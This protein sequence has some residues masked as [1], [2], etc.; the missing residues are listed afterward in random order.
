VTNATDTS[1]TTAAQDVTRS[2]REILRATAMT[3]GAFL[4]VLCLSMVRMK[5][6]ALA[7]GPDGIGFVGLLT[8]VLDMAIAVAGLGIQAS[9]VRQI[10]ESAGRNDERSIASVVRAVRWASWVSGLAGA[11]IVALLALPLSSLTFGTPAHGPD[12]LV[13]AAAVLLR[14]LAAGQASVL[15][16]TRRIGDLALI[17]I[18]GALAATIAMVPAAYFWGQTG[19][20]GALLAA[21]A[22]H[23]A[24]SGWFARKVRFAE[25]P[26]W[27]ETRRELPALLQMGVAFMVSGLVTFGVAYLMRI[28]VLRHGG[29]AEA[30]L[31]QAAW[32]IASLYASFVL[33]AMSTDFY[34]RLTGL[35]DQTEAN[36]LVNEQ[37]QVS[38][39]LAGP[40]MIATITL[41][42]LVL[43]LFYS[44]EFGQAASTLRWMCLGMALRLIAWPLGFI[45]LARGAQRIFF[46]T[47]IAAGAIHVG[48]ALVLV[49]IW[50]TTGAGMAFCGLYV[51]HAALIYF[52]VRRYFGFE[53]DGKTL[54]FSAECLGATIVAFA[55]VYL[56]PFWPGI[57]LGLILLSWSS[58]RA[59]RTILPLL[60]P[61]AGLS[62]KLGLVRPS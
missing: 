37:A 48:L 17:N 36:R 57:V 56:L 15:Q 12:M 60:T 14:L 5:L 49:P 18:F 53:I 59:L 51:W 40:G 21:S 61:L 2:Y 24:V 29:I 6:V 9:G 38:V 4:V 8:A 41:A 19:M 42:P 47:E 34:P 28:I 44:P 22:G 62:R 10:A 26:A 55:G 52:I 31:Y 33:Q 32:A 39:L 45:V 20:A 16:G 25:R 27:Q 1:T 11:A 7:L 23:L 3:G 54:R 46:W 13:L 58:L 43:A 50:G 30:G 35:A